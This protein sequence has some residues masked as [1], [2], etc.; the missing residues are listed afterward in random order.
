MYVSATQLQVGSLISIEA[1]RGRLAP[2]SSNIECMQIVACEREIRYYLSIRLSSLAAGI[3]LTLR[4]LVPYAAHAVRP[5][6]LPRSSQVGMAKMKGL[7]G[8]EEEEEE[9]KIGFD[10]RTDD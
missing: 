10:G 5:S 2:T 8:K 7:V 4:F 6:V 3:A 9:E 1:G